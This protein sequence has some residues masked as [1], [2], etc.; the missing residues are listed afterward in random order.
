MPTT[1]TIFVTGATGTVGTEV[2]K[3]LAAAGHH[4]TALVRNPSKA[5]KTRD[6]NVDVVVGDMAEPELLRDVL[7][8]ADKMFLLSS[9]LAA[10][11]LRVLERNMLDEAGKGAITHIV[12]LSGTG[13]EL[14]PG[15][16]L[17]RWHRDSEE[18]IE[19]SEI[20]WT[21]LRPSA[22]MTNLLFQAGSIKTQ[23]AF[24]SSMGDGKLP[25]I[26]PRDIAA[27][28]MTVLTEAGHAGKAYTLTGPEPLSQAELAGQLSSALGE[29]VSYIDVADAAVRQSMIEQV[30]APAAL[31]DAMLEFNHMV[32]EG[33]LEAV[34]PEVA[35]LTGR[36]PRTFAAWAEE[37][38]HAF[39]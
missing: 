11:D 17:G 3:Q 12:K 24:Y 34:T 19:K 9:P 4:V 35:N 23:N 38:A 1:R 31:A 21:F 27:V 8:R 32:K 29:S 14:E 16:P 22:F 39:K 36:K 5:Q 6:A 18:A 13:A 33:L 10:G 28:A 2:V 25:V 20:D 26:D 15:Y 7:L 30:G 37:H